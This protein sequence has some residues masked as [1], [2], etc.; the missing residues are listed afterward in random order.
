MYRNLHQ[1]SSYFFKEKPALLISNTTVCLGNTIYLRSS[2]DGSTNSSFSWQGPDSFR[3]NVENPII[4]NA[5]NAKLGIYTVSL[6]RTGCPETSSATAT[7]SLSS[8]CGNTGGNIC[9]ISASN[10]GYLKCPGSLVSLNAYSNSSGA[11]NLYYYWAGPNGFT[12][13]TQNVTINNATSTQIGYYTVTM[14][15]TGGTCNGGVYTSQTLLSLKPATN[16]PTF[17]GNISRNIG[18]EDGNFYLSRNI[19]DGTMKHYIITGPNG[20]VYY[21]KSSYYDYFYSNKPSQSGTY[22]I[23]GIMNGECQSSTTDFSFSQSYNLTIL[24]RL[25]A[26]TIS[27][28][29]EGQTITFTGSGC[30]NQINWSVGTMTGFNYNYTTANPFID[31][32]STTTTY[33]AICKSIDGCLS[34]SSNRI[35]VSLSCTSMQSIQSGLWTNPSIW[36]CGAVPTS[37]NVTT[38]SAGHI[39]TIP[40]STSAFVRNLLNYGTLGYGQN[41]SLRIGQ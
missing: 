20:F 10:D 18:C 14:S 5:T 3:S 12:A 37:T 29:Q 8:G 28:A 11:S 19:S 31:I 38:I 21:G 30:S 26:P 27:N 6:T 16:T 40:S 24:S 15:V 36:S 34:P 33:W 7:V 25:Q 9:S 1:L 23:N 22:T 13:N 17:S 39:V 4:V 41:A 32:P 35:L 2:T